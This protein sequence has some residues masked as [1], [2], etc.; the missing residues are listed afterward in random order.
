M[1]FWIGVGIL[2]VL[3]S[4]VC[5]MMAMTIG[6]WQTIVLLIGSGVF[7]FLVIYAINLVAAG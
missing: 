2:A 4:I 3:F 6:W 7:A 5:G 1:N